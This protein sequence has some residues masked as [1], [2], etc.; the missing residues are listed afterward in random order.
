MNENNVIMKM[1]IIIKWN[2]ENNDN[3]NNGMKYNEIM[4]MTKKWNEMK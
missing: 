3:S 4:K 1:I 2:N